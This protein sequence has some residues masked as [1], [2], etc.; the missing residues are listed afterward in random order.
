MLNESSD[1]YLIST[2][3]IKGNCGLSRGR[4]PQSVHLQDISLLQSINA[5]VRLDLQHIR[6]NFQVCLM[7]KTPRFILFFLIGTEHF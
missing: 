3:T 4:Y 7:T 2:V 1:F 6:L 5:M